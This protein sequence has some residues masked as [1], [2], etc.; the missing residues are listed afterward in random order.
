MAE[1]IVTGFGDTI[2][3]V[4]NAPAAMQ[5]AANRTGGGVQQSTTTN[6]IFLVNI[7]GLVELV[8]FTPSFTNFSARA[9]GN[10]TLAIGEINSN[11]FTLP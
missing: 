9:P 4:I 2:D 11:I 7:S 5:W 1:P 8:M 3:D 6:V 10:I